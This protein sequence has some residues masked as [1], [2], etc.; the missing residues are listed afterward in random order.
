MIKF[1]IFKNSYITRDKI[2]INKALYFPNY[3]R[4]IY[5]II[6]IILVKKNMFIENNFKRYE[7]RERERYVFKREPCFIQKKKKKEEQ[8]L[9]GKKKAKLFKENVR[10]IFLKMNG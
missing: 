5:S 3:L 4:G 1:H 2:K 10:S 9:S 6:F 7:G 8:Y